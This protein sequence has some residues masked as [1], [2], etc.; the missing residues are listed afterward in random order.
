[1]VQECIF[2]LKKLR[3]TLRNCRSVKRTNLANS[4]D[5]S[6][7]SNPRN[8]WIICQPKKGQILVTYTNISVRG[9]LNTFTYLEQ[10][11]FLGVLGPSRFQ[12]NIR[13]VWWNI[14]SLFIPF[15][16]LLSE[17]ALKDCGK[18]FLLKLLIHCFKFLSVGGGSKRHEHLH[19][20]PVVNQTNEPSPWTDH[21][22][23]HGL[24]SKMLTIKPTA[25]N[26]RAFVIF[27]VYKS[28]LLRWSF[29]A[30]FRR[31]IF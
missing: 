23:S 1:L 26:K 7:I 14:N 17:A 15:R 28:N 9:T 4:E 22:M 2:D 3:I 8:F 30:S 31:I 25:I 20:Y 19:V 27:R 6:F 21:L 11:A 13:I 18:H 16:G 24:I 29:P 10:Y 12:C 5:L